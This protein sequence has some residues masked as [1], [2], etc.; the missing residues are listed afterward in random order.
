MTDPSDYGT[1]QLA[2]RWAVANVRTGYEIAVAHRLRSF[3]AEVYCP[4]FERMTRPARRRKPEKVVKAAYPG[5][6]FV[7]VETIRNME[8]VY[9]EPDFHYFVRN[10]GNLSLLR[11][12]VISDLRRLEALGVFRPTDIPGLT[13]LRAGDRVSVPEGIFGG[14]RGVVAE[15]LKDRAIVGGGDFKIDTEIPALLLQLDSV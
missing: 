7:N 12:S 6:I 2:R 3:E 1:P 5:Y 14:M 9:N 4:Q 13:L 8:A 10:E 11:E 15:I